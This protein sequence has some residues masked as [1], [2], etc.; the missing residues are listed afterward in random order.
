ML[1]PPIMPIC[2]TVISI[3][4]IHHAE[5]AAVDKEQVSPEDEDHGHAAH[6]HAAH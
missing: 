6:T 4:G 3:E 2:R 5:I 1:A